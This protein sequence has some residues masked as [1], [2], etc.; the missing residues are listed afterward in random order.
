MIKNYLK[1]ALRN[2]WKY[3][4]FSLIN[5][6]G[7]SIGIASSILVFLFI[8][9]EFRTDRCHRNAENIYQ[10]VMHERN[11]ASGEVDITEPQPYPLGPSLQED[12]PEVLSF[13]RF[14]ESEHYIKTTEQAQKQ[15]IVFADSTLF[16]VFNFP[17]EQGNPKLALKDASSVALSH[18]KARQLFGPDYA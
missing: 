3:K 14:R 7:L 6:V 1:I 8:R 10:V 13:V 18:T 17:L 12:L 2:F 9:D 5:L 15:R 16:Q 4:F 11:L